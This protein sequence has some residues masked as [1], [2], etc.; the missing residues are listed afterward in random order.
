MAMTFSID[1]GRNDGF[2]TSM[3]GAWE[4][5]ILDG[6]FMMEHELYSRGEARTACIES[7]LTVIDRCTTGVT[8][9]E[10]KYIKSHH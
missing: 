9:H 6:Y 8:Y 4:S 1:R 2:E 3:S 5:P 7:H 10:A